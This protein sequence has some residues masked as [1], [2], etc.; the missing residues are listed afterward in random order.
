MK[1]FPSSPTILNVAL[2]LFV[3]ILSDSSTIAE[4]T[5]G[6]T[7]DQYRPISDVFR[8]LPYFVNGALRGYRIYAGADPEELFGE[9][10][11]EIGDLIVECAPSAPMEQI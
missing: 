3:T 4:E 11:L 7:A 2:A 8:P 10:G 6:P 9:L 1:Y 5:H